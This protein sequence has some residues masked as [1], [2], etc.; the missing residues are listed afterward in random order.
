MDRR[1]HQDPKAKNVTPW[2]RPHR[3]AIADTGH[4]AYRERE[5]VPEPSYCGGCGVIRE[6]GRW[7]WGARAKGA[8]EHT[9]PA[10]RRIAD[11]YPAGF[12]ELSGDFL[13]S[14]REE[15]GNLIKNEAEAESREHPLNRL[16]HM[17]PAGEGGL[18]ITTTDVHLPRRIG[19]AL[20]GAYK[21][22]FN[23]EYAEDD[24]VVHGT[25]RR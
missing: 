1:S 17:E 14:H 22:E 5:H 11:N 18:S 3:T 12:L 20:H 9:C 8:P 15:I 7:A 23:Y 19:E 25:W 10:C 21:G 2:K 24:T 13:A 4:D 16:M 6:E